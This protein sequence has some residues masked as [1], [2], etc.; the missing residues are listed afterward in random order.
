MQNS[1]SKGKEF[2]L[3]VASMLRS[4]LKIAVQRDRRSGA[5][6]NKSDISDYWN[7]LPLHLELKDQETIKIKE[8]FRQADQASS[9]NKAPTVVFQADEEV[10]ATLRLSDLVNF[11]IEIADLKAEN[12][13]LRIPVPILKPRLDP[14]DIANKKVVEKVEQKKSNPY[15]EVK[16]CRAGHIADHYGYCMQL[17]CKFSRG[18]KVKKK[19]GK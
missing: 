14:I 9:F 11:L 10:L 12:D 7:Q 19:K 17:D 15:L 2:E 5:G 18:Y 6:I 3:R 16:E 1:Y 8:W 13:D 4:K